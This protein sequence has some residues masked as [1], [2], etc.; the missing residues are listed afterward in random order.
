MARGLTCVLSKNAI[1]PGRVPRSSH[2]G[3]NIGALTVKVVALREDDRFFK[4]VPRQGRPLKVLKE[5]LA[6]VGFAEA[7][8]FGVSGHL[9]YISEVASIQRPARP[10]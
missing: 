7:G 9:G 8:Y 3:V 2:V 6:A 1:P 5:A 10:M 4:V